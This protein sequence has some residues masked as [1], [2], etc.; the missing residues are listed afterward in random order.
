MVV[1]WAKRLLVA[2]GGELGPE[3][4]G[5]LE[6]DACEDHPTDHQHDPDHARHLDDA[7]R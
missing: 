2:N 7:V 6:E 3:L 1:G 4:V 5:N